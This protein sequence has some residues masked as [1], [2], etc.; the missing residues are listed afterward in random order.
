MLFR[1][2][3]SR[4]VAA[5]EARLNE[6]LTPVDP[7]SV[8]SEEELTNAVADKRRA[9]VAAMAAL[10]DFSKS[11]RNKPGQRAADLLKN[12]AITTAELEAVKAGHEARK[13]AA[14]AAKV[15]PSQ[16]GESKGVGPV[17]SRLAQAT[18]GAQAISAIIRTG[19]LFQKLLALRIRGFVN[20]VKIVVLEK[21]DPLPEALTKGYAAKEWPNSRGLFV[22]DDATGTRTVYLRGESEEIGRAHV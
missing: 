6:A 2:A 8:S 21:G 18:N 16:L 22:Y 4:Q 10:Y 15:A 11:N 7:E 3:A 12:P 17:E 1:S 13:Q 5:L 9:K 14:A 19:S 20:N